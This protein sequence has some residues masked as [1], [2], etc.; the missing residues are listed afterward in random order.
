MINL[1]KTVLFDLDG[2]LLP[3]D[4]QKF[5]ETYFNLLGKKFYSLGYPP[6][7]MLQA[8]WAGTEAMVNNDGRKTNEDVFWEVFENKTNIKRSSI[9]SEFIH[10][11]N[12]QFDF[13]KDSTNPND[14]YVT[15]INQLKDKGYQLVLATNPIFPEI[16]T[17]K[18]MAW[19]NLETSLF[20]LITTYENSFYAKPNPNYYSSI[21]QELSLTFEECLMVG[22]DVNEDMIVKEM[23]MQVFL[24]TDC[25]N[26]KNNIDI[27]QF[28][29]GNLTILQDYLEK[30]P[31]IR[32]KES[33]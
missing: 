33:K 14:A 2:T 4:E 32:N 5:I 30:L 8:V 3:L 26:N 29:N 7:T 16:A 27:S 15:M 19:A 22:N 31:N 28:P 11:Y 6:K 12:N 23:G 17:K 13:V 18:R 9:E 25:L 20:S 21:C 24:L 1:I 10:F